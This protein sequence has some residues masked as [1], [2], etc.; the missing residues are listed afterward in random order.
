MEDTPEYKRA[1]NIQ[2]SA[3]DA[4]TKVTDSLTTLEKVIDSFVVAVAIAVCSYSC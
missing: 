3:N 1:L 4:L 2:S